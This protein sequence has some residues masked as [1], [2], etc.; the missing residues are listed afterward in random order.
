MKY[1]LLNLLL[2]LSVIG[3]T[4]IAFGTKAG[5]HSYTLNINDNQSLAH[6]IQEASYGFHLGADLKFDIAG[7][8]FIPSLMLN[9]VS[10]KYAVNDPDVTDLNVN[11]LNVEIPV[12]LGYEFFFLNI[13][14]GPVAHFRV[15][16]YDELV[17][18]AEPDSWKTALLGAQ[19]GTRV[20]LFKWYVDLRYEKNFYSP[21]PVI[22]AQSLTL[23]DAY[24][25][26]MLSVGRNLIKK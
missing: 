21:D 13:F 9:R 16:G 4:Q 5:L 8:T 14:G 11:Q 12:M 7:V 19:V 15:G 1:A 26:I 22:N 24:S 2:C 25:R 3:S 18:L 17:A 10:A 20:S 6:S 23:V